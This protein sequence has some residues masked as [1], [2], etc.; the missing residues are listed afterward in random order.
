MDCSCA[1]TLKESIDKQEKAVQKLLKVFESNGTSVLLKKEFADDNVKKNMS[2]AILFLLDVIKNKDK[3]NKSKGEEA[4]TS[5]KEIVAT[6]PGIK[7]KSK[8]GLVKE[9]GKS[10][11]FVKSEVPEK[12]K[13]KSVCFAFKFNK[14]P[15]KKEDCQNRHPEKCQ[16]FCDFG[17]I[18][19]DKNGC[20]TKKC[21]LLH[22]K[23]CRNS[24]AKKECPHRRC[25][26]QHLKGTKYVPK[27]ENQ[28][29][30]IP[31]GNILINKLMELLV[32]IIQDQEDGEKI[33]KT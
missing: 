27:A 16:K 1:L 7:S 3:D 33:L 25:R 5:N 30:Q 15:H 10:E 9:S 29:A 8:E 4:K 23:L 12:L 11:E 22:P 32:N 19:V 14:C 18:A 21:D 31:K 28:T 13:S 17:H 2:K 26:F 20:D 24:T 6:N